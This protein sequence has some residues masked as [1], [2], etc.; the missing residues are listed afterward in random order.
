MDK[1]KQKNPHVSVA[2]G[3]VWDSV[4]GPNKYFAWRL[5]A[6]FGPKIALTHHSLLIFLSEA[7]ELATRGSSEG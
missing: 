2:E 7:S 1:I 4:F 3:A 6:A 5:E